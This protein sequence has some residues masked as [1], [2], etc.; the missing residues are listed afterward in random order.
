[1]PI[2]LA[3]PPEAAALELG[4][5]LPPLARSAAIE[6]RAPAIGRAASRFGLKADM[7]IARTLAEVADADV[8]ASPVYALGLDQ[9]AKGRLEDAA[10]LAGWSWVIATE[11]GAVSAETTAESNRFAQISNAASAGRFRRALLQLAQGG[12]DADGEAVQLRIPA[13]HTSLLWI[14]GKREVYEVLDTSV[15]GLDVGRRYTGAELRKILKPEA[16]ARLRNPELDG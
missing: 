10:R 13:L 12:G 3:T 2:T 5:R 6:A 4:E 15:A 14:K 7:R 9:L 1:M 8:V 11:A 16:E